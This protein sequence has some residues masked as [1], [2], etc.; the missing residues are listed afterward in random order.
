M[1]KLL[2]ALL[3]S[4]C[5]AAALAQ[6]RGDILVVFDGWKEQRGQAWEWD[7]GSPDR[8]EPPDAMLCFDVG[9]GATSGG[10]NQA[11][12]RALCQDR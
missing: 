5:A 9:N 6:P 2:L 1:M 8:S 7:A 3:A 12:A 4:L 11:E 10:C